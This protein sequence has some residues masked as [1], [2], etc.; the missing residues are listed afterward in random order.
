MPRVP[1]P[2]VM[3]FTLSPFFVVIRI[4]GLKAFTMAPAHSLR[5]IFLLAMNN[6]AKRLGIMVAAMQSQ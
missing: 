2:I 3:E 5:F 6:N 1:H 4:P